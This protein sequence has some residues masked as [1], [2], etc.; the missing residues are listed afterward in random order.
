M[1]V[2]GLGTVITGA[3]GYPY[4]L[5]GSFLAGGGT[6]ALG[7]YART[8]VQTLAGSSTLGKSLALQ[9]TLR[10]SLRPLGLVLAGVSA[11]LFGS[12]VTIA[13]LGVYLVLL[14]WFGLW[15]ARSALGKKGG[16]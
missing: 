7:L 15:W 14:G 8:L 2:L 6:I 16:V 10:M 3:V 1:L 11:E 4:L 5:T 12:R 9:R 13:F